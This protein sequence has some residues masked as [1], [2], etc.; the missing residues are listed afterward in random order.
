M[1]MMGSDRS[2][3]RD[4]SQSRD[5]GDV[6]VDPVGRES[7]G[8]EDPSNRSERYYLDRPK[9]HD[10]QGPRDSSMRSEHARTEPLS[11]PHS[12]THVEKMT[13]RW[14]RMLKTRLD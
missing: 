11:F 9:D 1:S 3:P 8:P 10:P 6:P 12:K 2:Q 14:D 4:T 5:H 7:L 13:E